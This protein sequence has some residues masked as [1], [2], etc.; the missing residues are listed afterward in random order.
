MLRGFLFWRLQ[1]ATVLVVNGVAGLGEVL[2]SLLHHLLHN[3]DKLLSFQLRPSP[4]LRVF[5]I[6]VRFSLMHRNYKHCPR[7]SKR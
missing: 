7:N 2:D 6:V 4:G 1:G 3:S 5:Y